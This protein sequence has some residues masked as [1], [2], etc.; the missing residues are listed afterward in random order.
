M[1]GINVEAV[2]Y[3]TFNELIDTEAA[4]EG[5]M[6]AVNQLKWEKALNATRREAQENGIS[7]MTL[8]EIN[9]EIFAVRNEA[10]N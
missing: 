6:I 2:K 1:G 5:K 4:L 9:A 10:V 3:Y 7:N 8:D